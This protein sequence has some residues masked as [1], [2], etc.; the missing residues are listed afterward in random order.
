MKKVVIGRVAFIQGKNL[1]FYVTIFGFLQENMF[2]NSLDVVLYSRQSEVLSLKF[3]PFLTLTL[4]KTT[5]YINNKKYYYCIICFLCVLFRFKH[6]VA[7]I[8]NNSYAFHYIPVSRVSLSFFPLFLLSLCF[9]DFLFFLLCSFYFPF[10]FPPLSLLLVVTYHFVL[11]FSTFL[12]L[13]IKHL[14]QSNSKY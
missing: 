5:P 2:Q 14:K 8:A 7:E 6:S 1:C 11:C 13:F 3:M 9:I 12:V 10:F 4:L